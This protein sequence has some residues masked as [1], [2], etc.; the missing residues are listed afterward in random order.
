MHS[1]KNWSFFFTNKAGQPQGEVLGWIYPLSKISFNC[2]FNSANS[3][4]VI[5][6]GRLEIGAVSGCSSMVNSTS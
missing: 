3:L 6:Y 4:G 1:L 5:L 2:T